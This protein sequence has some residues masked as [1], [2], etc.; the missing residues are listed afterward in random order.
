MAVVIYSSTAAFMLAR[1]GLP[2]CAIFTVVNT[3]FL[4]TPGTDDVTRWY[5]G[6]T[7]LPVGLALASPSGD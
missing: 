7:L 6:R 5:A 2:A 1:H 3:A 4:D